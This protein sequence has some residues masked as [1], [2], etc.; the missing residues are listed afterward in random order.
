MTADEAIS[1]VREHGVVL[2][3]ARGPA[4]KLVEAIAGEF[5]NGSWWAHPRSRA[6]YA[7]LQQVVASPEI[8]L[9]RLVD[10]K[11]TVVH[12]RLWPALVR[13]AGRIG[14][15]RLGQ[16]HQE[17]TP[18]G[19][20][21]SHEIAFPLWVPREVLQAAQGLNEDQALGLCATW[22]AQPDTTGRP[23]RRRQAPA[24]TPP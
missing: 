24:G 20:H 3:S 12:R 11:L 9:C 18:A 2:V 16:V 17:H 14:V 6:I 23:T 13:L 21:I 22:V 5:I 19:H 4:P 10:A 1:F 15:E 8:L 7:T